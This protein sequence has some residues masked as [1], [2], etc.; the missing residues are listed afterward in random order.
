MSVLWLCC[1]NEC[2]E[3]EILHHNIITSE[4]SQT[5]TPQDYSQHAHIYIYIYDASSKGA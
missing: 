3:C 4:M 1:S 5:Y 2:V